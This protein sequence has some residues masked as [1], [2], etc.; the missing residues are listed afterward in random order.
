L[1]LSPS[2]SLKGRS[3]EEK[4][5]FRDISP[6]VA[7]MIDLSPKM[8]EALTDQAFAASTLLHG[9]SLEQHFRHHQQYASSQSRTTCGCGVDHGDDGLAFPEDSY[10][11]EPDEE[12]DE[13]DEDEDEDGEDDEDEED[14]DSMDDEE[15]DDDEQDVVDGYAHHYEESN[16]KMMAYEEEKLK[17]ESVRR[18]RDEERR[19]KEEFRKKK[20]LERQKQKE[21]KGKDGQGLQFPFGSF[22][23]FLIP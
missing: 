4:L 13:D 16:V 2:G 22:L 15:Y 11:D 9:E 5:F 18:V 7:A 17:L 10:E 14:D 21:E 23:S 12:D 19:L 1:D 3:T 8:R 20:I 6:F